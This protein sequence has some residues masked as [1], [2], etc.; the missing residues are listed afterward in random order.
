MLRRARRDR[1]Y[2][3]HLKERFGFLPSTRPGGIWLHA[4]SVGEVLSAVPL[5]RELKRRQPGVPISVSVTTVAGR[6]LAEDRLKNLADAL[7]YAPFDY[8]SIVRRC[9]R[10]LRP[11]AVVILETE[12]WPNLWAEARKA[13]AA[14]VVVNGRISDRALPRYTR[15]RWFFSHVLQEPHLI[16]AQSAGDRERY[17]ALG[18]S[19]ERT[20]DGGNLKYD[21]AAPA[22]GIPADL[23]EFLHRTAPAETLIAASTMPPVDDA[24]L[25]EDDAVL[26]AFTS[27]GER[28]PRLLLILVPRRPE[29]FAAAAAKLEARGI[30]FVRRSQLDASTTL[31]LPGVLLLDSMGELSRLFAL[32]SVVFI[33]GT[34]ARRGGHNPLEPAQ[35]A[36]PI[37]A[38]PHMENFAAMAAE[39]D[40]ANA[41]RRISGPSDLAAA[42]DELLRNPGD[43]GSAA[44]AISETG[45]GATNRAVDAILERYDAALPRPPHSWLR[46]LTL[47]SLVPLWWLGTWI[48]R[49]FRTGRER[50][51]G[52]V[53]SIGNLSVGGTGKTPFTLA[54]AKMLR[55]QGHEPA[56]LTRGYGRDS[57]ELVAL[58]PGETAPP[59][60]TG[61]EAQLYLAAGLAAAIGSD[62]RAAAR[63][64]L[65]R[66]RPAVWL[67]DDGFQHWPLPRDLDIVLI[68]TL[69]PFPGGALLP[70][71]RLRESPHALARAH[72]FVLT[73]CEPGRSY[74]RLEKLLREYRPAAPIYHASLVAR[75]W[76]PLDGGPALPLDSVRAGSGF[77]G[78]GNPESFRRTLSH[79]GVQLRHFT[80]FPDHHTFQ[81]SDFATLGPGPWLTTEKDAARLS[82]SLPQTV[83]WLR[84]ETVIAESDKF[85]RLLARSL[86]GSSR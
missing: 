65:T 15:W 82:R 1:R 66:I 67:L 61:D 28:H 4:V 26:D 8:V 43:L 9:L 58:T 51:P 77:C 48:D 29:R 80:V 3:A 12:I 60:Q 73:R 23:S 68:D 54:V 7:F 34:L 76:V 10:L 75:E 16:L 56:I 17:L 74:R 18:A 78:V 86:P 42:L 40:A 55:T 50:I 71:G 45:R 63:A 53:I 6:A 22:G 79:L 19:P 44:L 2:L 72:A 49:W 46:R 21:V 83:Y 62:R 31:P 24:D 13:G 27:L 57:T 41:W 37:L 47:G 32:Q 39:F 33:G 20:R 81:E 5:I 85:S 35:F 14:L 52:T 70:L 25:D 11:G 36:R 69:D 38:G 64:L 30:P 59:A 84:V